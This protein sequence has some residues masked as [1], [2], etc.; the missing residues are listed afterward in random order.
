MEYIKYGLQVYKC[1]ELIFKMECYD[2]RVFTKIY[3]MLNEYKD[4]ILI[5]PTE[6]VGGDIK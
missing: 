5:V 2:K 1:N 4:N 6:T 3:V